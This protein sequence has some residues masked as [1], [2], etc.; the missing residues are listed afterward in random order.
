MGSL[1][2][3]GVRDVITTAVRDHE[4]QLVSYAFSIL[5]DRDRARD[6][7]Q[8][9]FLKLHR[10]CQQNGPPRLV[11]PWL[12]AVCRN[13]CVDWLRRGGKVQLVD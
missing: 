4:S 5:G 2:E 13:R 12:F 9:S 8:D 11:K 7:A 6:A 10:E 3:D 1:P